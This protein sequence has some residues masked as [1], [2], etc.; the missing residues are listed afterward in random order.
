MPPS[1]SAAPAGLT[2]A[3]KLRTAHRRPGM[4]Y[5]ASSSP[6]CSARQLGL[7]SKASLLAS[8]PLHT[9]E[10]SHC[11]QRGAHTLASCPPIWQLA[12]PAT[13]P[14]L[15]GCLPLLHG[16][17]SLHSIRAAA[18]RARRLAGH[19]RHGAPRR[20]ADSPCV[21]A[22]SAPDQ[23]CFPY[24]KQTARKTNKL[25]SYLSCEVSALEFHNLCWV[26]LSLFRPSNGL[27]RGHPG[28]GGQLCCRRACARHDGPGLAKHELASGC[29]VCGVC[30]PWLLCIRT[31]AT[32]LTSRARKLPGNT[33]KTGTWQC[34]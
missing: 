8:P 13:Q 23:D 12:S 26:D 17:T 6:N 34:M 2:A 15:P 33:R 11:R 24:C 16:N 4:H 5:L 7:H 3:A 25:V 14:P 18:H 10:A 22:R 31:P 28:D 29:L 19:R 27:A 9:A 32:E 21:R 30:I 1:N 20:A